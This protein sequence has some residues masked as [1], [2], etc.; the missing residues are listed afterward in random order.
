MG[1]DQI[2][3][4]VIMTERTKQQFA[5]TLPDTIYLIDGGGEVSWCDSPEPSEGIDERD[6]VEYRKVVTHD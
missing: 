3:G 2:R 4:R 5:D 1:M 6:V